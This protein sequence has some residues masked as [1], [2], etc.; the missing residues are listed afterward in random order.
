MKKSVLPPNEHLPH[1]HFVFAH[2]NI[3]DSF[4][5]F[6]CRIWISATEKHVAPLFPYTTI[7]VQ[8]SHLTHFQN[9]FAH[10]LIDKRIF[11]FQTVLF[12]LLF[13]SNA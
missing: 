12:L 1:F 11:H 10:R 7:E 4:Q 6:F 2:V 5:F 8:T 9:M 13:L 3:V